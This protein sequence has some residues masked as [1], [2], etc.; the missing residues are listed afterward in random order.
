MNTQA[1]PEISRLNS[2]NNGKL[3]FA[4]EKQKHHPKKGGR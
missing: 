1:H 2:L 3:A 4:N